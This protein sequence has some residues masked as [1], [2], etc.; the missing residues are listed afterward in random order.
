[1]LSFFS[2]RPPPPAPSPPPPPHGG[3]QSFLKKAGVESGASLERVL[4]TL[5]EQEVTSLDLLRSYWAD[6]APLLKIV[7]RK[8]I[9]AALG[10]AVPSGGAGTSRQPRPP[11]P[12]PPPQPHSSPPALWPAMV[13]CHNLRP[14]VPQPE[15]P[16]LAAIGVTSHPERA[17]IRQGARASWMRTLPRDV[18]ARFVLPGLQVDSYVHRICVSGL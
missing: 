2:S 18:H 12:P 8:R 9:E 5:N 1:M 3:L 4:A 11:P 14:M 6:V 15:A 16:L 10:Q 13:W 7:P 17:L